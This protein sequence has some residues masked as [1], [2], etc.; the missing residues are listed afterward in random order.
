MADINSDINLRIRQTG[1]QEAAR[2]L[3][4]LGQAQKNLGVEGASAA[5]KLRGFYR[6]QR[7]QDR[8]LRE[9]TQSV[10]A[11]SMAFGGG[12][13]L[14][15]K[16]GPAVLGMQQAEF[17]L[18]GLGIAAESAGGKFARFGSV[19]MGAAG[20]AGIAA[21]AT[22]GFYSIIFSNID[23]IHKLKEAIQELD[24]ELGKASRVEIMMEKW[25]KAKTTEPSWI[26]S[27]QGVGAAGNPISLALE[28][29]AQG[30]RTKRILSEVSTYKGFQVSSQRQTEEDEQKAERERRKREEEQRRQA[31]WYRRMSAVPPGHFGPYPW[32]MGG[33]QYNYGGVYVWPGA[34][35]GG[36]GIE[37]GTID[38]RQGGP[39]TMFGGDE[40]KA[41]W[42]KQQGE[43]KL[44]GEIFGDISDTL[45]DSLGGAF[46][47]IFGEANTLVEQLAVKILTTL[48]MYGLGAIFA[49][50]GGAGVALG[51][52]F[53]YTRSS[54]PVT[55][56]AGAINRQ[57]SQ[58]LAAQYASDR[59]TARRARMG[60]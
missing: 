32:E 50:F 7:V 30:A 1:A 24:I 53:G 25:F 31:E 46:R 37:T 56:G 42:N 6:E 22:L 19:L 49:S 47:S 21:G 17:A 20:P 54:M 36:V 39:Q 5:Q 43:A 27:I 11:L 8:T 51:S 29:L 14:A 10:L 2:A 9:G 60:V 41:W 40:F 35:G 23:A 44:L 52:A 48:S 13:G 18:T 12:S 45:R 26:E 15:G 38:L 57:A 59:L 4:G 16:L 28:M 55:G 33:P 3:Q 34:Q 58:A